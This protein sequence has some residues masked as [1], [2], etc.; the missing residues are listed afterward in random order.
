M[1]ASTETL[2]CVS[3]GGVRKFVDAFYTKVRI[4]PEL[5]SIFA[6]RFR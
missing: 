3:G 1:I 5:A 6:R 2:N 4:A